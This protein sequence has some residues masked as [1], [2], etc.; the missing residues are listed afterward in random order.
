MI[1]K[2]FFYFLLILLILVPVLYSSEQTF[3]NITVYGEQKDIEIIHQLISQLDMD[4]RNFQRSIGTYLDSKISISIAED[5]AEYQKWTKGN[6]KI[7]EFSNAFYNRNSD[8]IYLRH[9]SQLKSLVALR[10]ILLHEYIH[11]FVGKFWRNPPLW[12]NEG[13]SV[14]FTGDLGFERELNFAKNYVMGNSR[15]LEMMKY[16][17]PRNQIE[18]ESFYAKSALAVKYL[19]QKR[20]E[21][22]RL[23][24]NSRPQGDFEPAFRRSFLMTT[25][26]FSIIFEEYARTH[27]RAE[28]LLASTGMI[29]SLLPLI[30]IIGVIR[31]N[32]RNRKKIKAWEKEENAHDPVT[33]SGAEGTG[34][35]KE[36]HERI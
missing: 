21:F 7:I 29:W 3:E 33:V 17:Y 2:K 35:Q 16:R 10:R 9:P 28:L 18:W 32:I 30:L 4:I 11:H 36:V 31:K 19:Y 24:D 20:Q 15:S 23:W 5:N 8:T 14:Y 25:R 6:G 22:Y 1:S 12:F 26:D 27:F 34:I 13:M